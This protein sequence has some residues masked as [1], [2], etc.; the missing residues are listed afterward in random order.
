MKLVSI[1]IQGQRR[2]GVLQDNERCKLVGLD[3][4]AVPNDLDRLIQDE[5][6]MLALREWL[7][8]GFENAE[9]VS[10]SDPA[11]TVLAPVVAPQKV[12]CIGTNYADHAREMG[13][14]PA[15]IP[16][17][18][19][20]FP[21]AIVGTGQAVVLPAISHQVDFEAELVV[22]IGTAG[23]NIPRAEA[24]D[25]V[26]G[27]CNGN[28]ISARDW[29]KGKP[30]GQWLL[31]KTFD[32]FAPLG[33]WIAT[34]DEIKDPHVLDIQLRLNGEVMQDSNTS[35]LIFPIDFL[36][37]HLSKFVTLIPGDLV[38]TGTPAG[39]GAGRTP[40]VFLKPGDE[41]EVEIEGLGVLA[42][43]VLAAC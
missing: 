25:H 38:F 29:Q 30:G 22:V 23:R 42:N 27:Y 28:D 5:N 3:F 20:V 14:Q 10:L 12:I 33:P 6:G 31:G 41:I 11:V 8:S 40:Q 35:E 17:V 37:S 32:T 24:M 36:I 9:D 19:N 15:E 43:P 21:S 39:V 4:E 7:A 18:F 26:F 2:I 34:A 16:V 1:K 13:G